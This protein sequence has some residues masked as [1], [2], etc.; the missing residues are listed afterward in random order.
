VCR[1]ISLVKCQCLKATIENKDFRNNIFKNLTTGNDMYLSYCL[2]YLSLPA[3]FTSDGQCVRLA[4]R[5]RTQAVD[6]TDQWRGLVSDVDR[7]E[8]FRLSL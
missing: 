8:H 5:Q 3:V 6:T 2:N 4:A 1:Y 7:V